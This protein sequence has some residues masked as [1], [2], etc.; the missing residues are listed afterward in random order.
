MTSEEKHSGLNRE[1][2][3]MVKKKAQR[4]SQTNMIFLTKTENTIDF[5]QLSQYSLEYLKDYKEALL[6]RKNQY[7]F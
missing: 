4:N 3:V 7:C 2:G 5:D 6:F 1:E